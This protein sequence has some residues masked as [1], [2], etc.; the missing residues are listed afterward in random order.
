MLTPQRV[1]DIGREAGDKDDKF[2]FVL[3][4]DRDDDFFKGLDVGGITGAGRHGDDHIVALSRSFADMVGV[5]VG[6]TIFGHGATLVR[7]CVEDFI[8]IVP[9]LFNTVFVV[10]VEVD[11]HD[12][13]QA[14]LFACA[15]DE[16]IEIVHYAEAE[17][18]FAF[19]MGSRRTLEAEGVAD[20]A[21]HD[22]IQCHEV[23]AHCL[24]YDI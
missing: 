6:R 20:M 2:R 3:V 12:P 9:G 21:R 4:G 7:F 5:F 10:I 23:A 13:F 1:E 19:R 17:A 14:I 22:L 15:L 16:D 18:A 11:E 24:G 8:R